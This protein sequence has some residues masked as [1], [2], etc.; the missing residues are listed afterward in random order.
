MFTLRKLLLGEKTRLFMMVVIFIV[1]IVFSISI[2][3]EESDLGTQILYIVVMVF[4]LF[5][6]V[7]SELLK[8]LFQK[9]TKLLVIE[10]KPEQAYQWIQKLKKFDII[11]GYANSILVFET[12]FYRDQGDRENLKKLL[13]DPQFQR[14]SSLKLVYKVN[15]FYLAIE[16]KDMEKAA[17]LHKEI[18]D[19]YL[20]K[21]KRRYAARPVYSLSQI[22]AD[23]YIAKGNLTKAYDALRNIKKETLNNREQTYYYVSFAQYYRLK[24]NTRAELMID[25]AK[26]LGPT[27][28]HV[29]SI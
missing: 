12:L 2:I 22:H 9:G 18:T 16:D 27:L 23:Y 25:A 11:K 29:K 6:F 8:L 28:A 7:L 19:M 15:M 20:I 21:T 14:S 3:L 17:S 4:F 24:E 26:A 1:F 5:F 13:E 10:C